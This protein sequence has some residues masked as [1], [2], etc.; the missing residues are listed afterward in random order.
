MRSD[1]LFI[2]L[3]EDF[4]HTG[5]GFFFGRVA[6]FRRRRFARTHEGLKDFFQSGFPKNAAADFCEGY[7]W[8]KRS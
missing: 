3:K 6:K 5:G 7:V 1:S 8:I 4:F 2:I